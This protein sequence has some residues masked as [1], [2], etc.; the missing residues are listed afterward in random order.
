MNVS[1]LQALNPDVQLEGDG[2]FLAYDLLV[3]TDYTL[4]D[5]LQC[6]VLIENPWEDYQGSRSYYV[7]A[8]LDEQASTVTAEALDFLWHFGVRT[9]YFPAQ[10]VENDKNAELYRAVD[11]ARF[12]KYT[13]LKTYLESVFTPELAAQ[14]AS[15]G[16]NAEYRCYTGYM[17]GENDELYFGGGE[18]GTNP[19]VLAQLCTEPRTQPDGSLVFGLLGIESSQAAGVGAPPARAVWHTIRLVRTDD[20]W[21]VAE[22]SL[23]V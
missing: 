5:S 7:P 14:Y 12:T 13:E 18:R 17:A 11:G 9:G 19:L 15:G 6:V 8:S 23:A 2:K 22:A 21:R 16:Y 20:G 3:D 1:E 4:P 10:P